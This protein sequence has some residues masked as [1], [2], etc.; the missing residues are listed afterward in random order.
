[1]GAV[2]RCAIVPPTDVLVA[3]GV[4]DVAQLVAAL[5]LPPA[6]S[7]ECDLGRGSGGWTEAWGGR[8]EGWRP[9]C[10]RVG[11]LRAEVAAVSFAQPMV[12]V[13]VVP[14]D[15][16]V[17][18]EGLRTALGP[19]WEVSSVVKSVGS[20]G[21]PL[22]GNFALRF[23]RRAGGVDPAQFLGTSQADAVVPME[24]LLKSVDASLEQGWGLLF[25]KTPQSPNFEDAK[26]VFDEVA[27]T[28]QLPGSVLDLAPYS[29]PAAVWGKLSTAQRRRAVVLLAWVVR[30]EAGA[31]ACCDLD[32]VRGPVYLGGALPDTGGLKM[33]LATRRGAAGGL[34]VKTFTPYRVLAARGYVPP[35]RANL[36]TLTHETAQRAAEAAMPTTVAMA[37]ILAV[38]RA[39]KQEQC[40][41]SR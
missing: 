6:L 20:V 21:L 41:D 4:V 23:L 30:S 34:V 39:K 1:M 29:F 7:V 24:D 12:A 5:R 13:V 18:D 22:R 33:F 28:G 10:A 26:S 40:A 3:D 19:G 2:A 37:S 35:D 15:A 16:G 17:T 36:S 8:R 32:A 25:N 11:T 31:G 38:V 14:P 9:R 27:K